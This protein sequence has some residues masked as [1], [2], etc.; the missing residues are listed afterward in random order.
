M[1]STLEWE[2][3]CTLGQKRFNV[4]QIHNRLL[5]YI[6]AN[7]DVKKGEKIEVLNV[8]VRI[9]DMTYAIAET[10]MRQLD[11]HETIQVGDLCRLPNFLGG[12][13]LGPMA[14]AVGK[15]VDE[16]FYRTRITGPLQVFRAIEKPNDCES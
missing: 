14:V 15:T 13:Y 8:R 1:I 12:E 7:P 4:V 3:I 16:M 11:W 6:R 2:L 10:G 5:L 9:I